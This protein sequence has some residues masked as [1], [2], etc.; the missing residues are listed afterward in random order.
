MKGVTLL[1]QGTQQSGFTS[2]HC[3]NV[4]VDSALQELRVEVAGT[5]GARSTSGGRSF[6]ALQLEVILRIWKVG[7]VGPNSKSPFLIC[8]RVLHTRAVF[9]QG[10]VIACMQGDDTASKKSCSV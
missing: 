2:A 4:H 8:S 10:F 7:R 3:T 1:S 6:V 5:P 9:S